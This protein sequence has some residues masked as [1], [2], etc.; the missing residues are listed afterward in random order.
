[1]NEKL[2]KSIMI[3]R[4][5]K[6]VAKFLPP[7]QRIIV[8]LELDN[9]AEYERCQEDTIAFIQEHAGTE[10]AARASRAKVLTQMEKL[11]QLAVKGKIKMCIKWIDD[12][13]DE[14]KLVV[15]CTHTNVIKQL[16]SKFKGEC[17]YIDGSV[18]QKDR[19]KAVD[20][21]QTDPDCRLFVGNLKA[22]GVGITLTAASATATIELGWVPGLHDQAEDRVNRIGQEA[23]SI[24]AYYLL[25]DDTID[26]DVAK[27]LDSKRKMI[28]G[29]LDGTKVEE[30]DLLI[31]LMKKYG[32]Q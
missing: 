18:S 12:F 4:L 15:F 29:V 8:P 2:T 21:F 7:K 27:M 32:S 13:I 31:E 23:S 3:R 22:A 6:D 24:S 26:I 5:K 20:K 28:T 17:V 1:M 14:E 30:H 11:K 25:A 16:V 10:A 9:R 19:Q